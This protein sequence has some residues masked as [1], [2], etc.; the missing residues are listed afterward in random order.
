MLGLHFVFAGSGCWQALLFHSSGGPTRRSST[1]VWASI[2][3]DI[4][5]SQAA[6]LNSA[7]S[8]QRV[9]L[10]KDAF[11]SRL[12]ESELFHFKA[13]SALKFRLW[14]PNNCLISCITSTSSHRS[15]WMIK[16]FMASTKYFLL[17]YC[18]SELILTLYGVW[19]GA[20]W[21]GFECV[22]GMMDD[23]CADINFVQPIN[24]FSDHVHFVIIILLFSAFIYCYM[25]LRQRHGEVRRSIGRD[26]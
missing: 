25:Y 14:L 24:R 1:L 11:H 15:S 8:P 6:T 26:K 3:V 2:E 13:S 10:Q 19:W 12:L 5:L 4:L 23:W 18:G 22:A 9:G 17:S 21:W 20:L 16:V 7:V